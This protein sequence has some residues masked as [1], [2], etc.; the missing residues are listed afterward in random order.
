MEPEKDKQYGGSQPRA[1]RGRIP[2][3][4]KVLSEWAALLA[5]FAAL[6]TFGAITASLI[7]AHTLLSQYETIYHIRILA[8]LISKTVSNNMVVSFTTAIAAAVLVPDILSIVG[9]LLLQEKI[10]G[11]KGEASRLWLSGGALFVFIAIATTLFLLW[12]HATTALIIVF[13]LAAFL[14]ITTVLGRASTF[15]RV[16]FGP[17]PWSSKRILL[18]LAA[19]ISV[20][21]VLPINVYINI[22]NINAMG[23]AKAAME[24]ALL[25]TA[26]M[27]LGGGVFR[28][29]SGFGQSGVISAAVLVGMIVVLVA[30]L[31][32]QIWPGFVMAALDY[33]GFPIEYRLNGSKVSEHGTLILQ[34][35][36][37]LY[38]ER[39][40]VRG[41][42]NNWVLYEVRLAHVKKW[43]PA[44]AHGVTNAGNGCRYSGRMHVV[45]PGGG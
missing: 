13:F 29:V 2:P 36:N 37:A 42:I 38:V 24:V 9:A 40:H 20:F 23:H 45:L 8:P 27:V 12:N 3:P 15:V 25:V 17:A 14:W 21:L 4:P 31:V 22:V 32:A 35:S 30:F 11:L 28:L 19:V 26:L 18:G 33:G 7:F 41:E 6:S 34:T 43:G 5:S 44:D 1:D 16:F 39:C 10:E